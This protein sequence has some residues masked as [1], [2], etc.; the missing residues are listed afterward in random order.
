M[1]NCHPPCR[2]T[3][4][5]TSIHNRRLRLAPSVATLVR[6]WWMPTDAYRLNPRH[7]LKR[8]YGHG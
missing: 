8:T 7:L 5:D 2:Q 4:V 3:S 1:E 6:S